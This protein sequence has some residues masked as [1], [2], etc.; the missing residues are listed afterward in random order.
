[1]IFKPKLC[2]LARLWCDLPASLAV[3][4]NPEYNKKQLSHMTVNQSDCDLSE[5]W[6]KIL[7]K[8]HSLKLAHT[9]VNMANPEQRWDLNWRSPGCLLSWVVFPAMLQSL[10][11]QAGPIW[12]VAT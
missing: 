3:V 9:L 5:I 4:S 10:R 12:T 8:L 1:M 11:T 7:S 2:Y 6:R